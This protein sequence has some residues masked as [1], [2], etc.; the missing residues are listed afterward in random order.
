M[1]SAKLLTAK[2]SL[3]GEGGKRVGGT[4]ILIS[5]ES[6]QNLL[7]RGS[8]LVVGGLVR[9]CDQDLQTRAA[10]VGRGRETGAEKTGRALP[11]RSFRS[12]VNRS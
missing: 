12:R 2:D 11:S 10:S 3:K 5:P 4:P 1:E 9:P 8:D 7:P 6:L